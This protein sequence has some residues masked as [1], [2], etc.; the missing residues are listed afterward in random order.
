MIS[1]INS[2]K[3]KSNIFDS[4]SLISRINC[5]YYLL[6]RVYSG[7]FIDFSEGLKPDIGDL[8]YAELNGLTSPPFLSGKIIS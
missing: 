5:L 4:T 6:S 7:R 8:V 2:L 1:S 3:V